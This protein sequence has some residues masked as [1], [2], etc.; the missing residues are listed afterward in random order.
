MDTQFLE[1]FLLVVE[2]GLVAQAARRLNLT[3]AGVTQRHKAM[4]QELGMALT[5]RSG[6]TAR[7]TE[8][9]CSILPQVQALLAGVRDL[10]NIANEKTLLAS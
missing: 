2:H 10:R 4:E 9:G 5:S 1:S 6:R 8:A 7:P 3:P